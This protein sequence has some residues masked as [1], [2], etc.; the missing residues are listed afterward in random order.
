M[1]KL[2]S[3]DL[4]SDFETGAGIRLQSPRPGVIAFLAP[5]DRSPLPMWFH[6]R[7]SGA[8]GH[9]VQFQLQN[10]YTCLGANGYEQCNVF[11]VYSAQSPKQSTLQ[12]KWTRVRKEDIRYENG[13]FSFDIDVTS[14]DFYVAHCYP[15]GAKALNELIDDFAAHPCLQVESAGRS[16]EGRDLPRLRITSGNNSK[17]IIWLS[18]RT[19]AGETG[20]AWTLDGLIRWLLSNE[21]EAGLCRDQ[22]EFRIFPM[23]DVDGVAHGYY[24]KD[25]APIDYNRAWLADTPLLEIQQI[26]REILD[27][28]DRSLLHI[29]FHSPGAGDANSVFLPSDDALPGFRS[30][31]P[32]RFAQ[33]LAAEAPDT[34]PLQ[35]SK[36]PMYMG[37][38]WPYSCG[39]AI[40]YAIGIPAFICEVSYG[41]VG[42]DCPM[43]L[44]D[45]HAYGAAV[46]R[47]MSQAL[48]GH[49][50]Q[51]LDWCEASHNAVP[52]KG[53]KGRRFAGAFPWRCRN[54]K[55]SADDQ[56]SLRVELEADG[57]VD[58]A[59]PL[60]P[61]DA[62]VTIDLEAIDCEVDLSITLFYL[63]KDGLRFRK[64]EH[65]TSSVSG[66]F[67]QSLSPTPPTNARYV[68]PSIALSGGP[69]VVHLSSTDRVQ[70]T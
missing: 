1:S 53:Y 14:N 44:D 19:H 32:R 42:S 31:L 47:A 37:S 9:R 40:R 29:D 15:Y 48:N 67:T 65:F 57:H 55:L 34:A 36:V 28:R 69:G 46:G 54:A 20:G 62:P 21:V 3:V 17:P 39:G 7:V 59:M 35:E 45:Y 6:F 26:L 70:A 50:L 68:Q 4:S 38:D 13:T 43:Q 41:F 25:R 27:N 2:W 10:A 51:H 60:A 11:P 61:V 23:V 66:R 30:E 22:Y 24:G 8:K 58:L 56:D 16:T 63:S 64:T 5:W 18:A 52:F 49:Q 33:F 12:R